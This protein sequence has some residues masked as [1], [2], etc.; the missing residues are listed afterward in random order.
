MSTLKERAEWALADPRYLH[1]VSINDQRAIFAAAL[2]GFDVISALK[3]VC[4]R[5]MAE[6]GAIDAA[7]L[8]AWLENETSVPTGETQ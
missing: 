6:R 5:A 8:L 3:A 1:T 2:H 4:A 7:T